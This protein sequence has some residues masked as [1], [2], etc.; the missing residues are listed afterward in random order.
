MVWKKS[1]NKLSLITCPGIAL[2]DKL[3][4]LDLFEK[5]KLKFLPD[6]IINLNQ[7]KKQL[8]KKEKNNNKYILAVGRLTKQKNFLIYFKNLINI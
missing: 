4:K 2:F 6:A 8:H 3:N 7:I 5:D 1:N